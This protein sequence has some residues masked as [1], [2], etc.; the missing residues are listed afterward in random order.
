M[1]PATSHIHPLCRPIAGSAEAN[2]QLFLKSLNLSLPE[3]KGIA[4]INKWRER[5]T[6]RQRARGS[7]ELFAESGLR[8]MRCLVEHERANTIMSVVLSSKP[9]QVF[10]CSNYYYYYYYY[11]FIELQ[12]GFHPVAMLLH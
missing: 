9:Y 11:Y 10:L 4:W 3:N 2:R 8:G 6:K 7:K 5:T 1:F 12:M